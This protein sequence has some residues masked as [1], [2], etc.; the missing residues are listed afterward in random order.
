MGLTIVPSGMIEDGSISSANIDDA[1]IVTDDIDSTT[2]TNAKM[3]VDPSNASNLNSGSIPAARLGNAGEYDKVKVLNDIATLALH[4]AVQNNQEAYNLANAFIDQF[5]DATGL[6]VLTNVKRDTSEY[7]TTLAGGG[8]DS[9]TL[10]LIASN[11]TNGS[12][13]FTDT[14][15]GGS[16]HSISRSGTVHSTTQK[17]FGTTS[18]F[19]DGATDSL[20]L[21][22]DSDFDFG[23][24]DFTID[25]W[26]YPSGNQQYGT[27]VGAMASTSQNNGWNFGYSNTQ[28]QFDMWKG[29]NATWAGNDGPAVATGAWTHLA[30]VKDGSTGNLYVNGTSQKSEPIVS[31]TWDTNA[32]NVFIGRRYENVDNYYLTAYMDEIRV[33]D[34][35]R[36]TADFSVP[37]EAYV[38]FYVN[39]TG[40]YTSTTQTASST[41]TKMSIVVLYKNAYGTATLDTD[42]VAQVSA[43]GGS[44][45]VSAPLTASGT[46]STGILVA[47]SNDI[48]ISTTGTAPKYKI[49][50]AN[51]VVSTKE[52]RVEGVAILY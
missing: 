40:N 5:E 17:K 44:N 30:F 42:L 9:N 43:D 50:L 8:N 3:A 47:K 2:I 49:S 20:W 25:A 32:T 51:Q 41:V 34:V 21:A 37:T 35:A 24:G 23:S 31:T 15:V 39:A 45:Y 19:N 48:T 16:T 12:T 38:P 22:A 10:L 36:W 7:M 26:I 11:T 6:D 13:T 29:G 27:I 33:S 14:S 1:T 28:N 18:I 46:F 4:Q 52:T